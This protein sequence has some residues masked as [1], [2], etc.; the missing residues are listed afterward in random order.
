MKERGR[1]ILRNIAE[2]ALDRF[3]YELKIKGEPLRGYASFLANCKQRG[4]EVR[5]VFDGGVGFGTQ[6]LYNAFPDKKIVLIE[7][8]KE[9]VPVMEDLGRSYDAEYHITAL[10]ANSG[11]LEINVA[12]E[13][14]TSSSLKE[15]SADLAA[16]LKERGRQRSF[17]QRIIDVNRLDDINKYEPPFLLKLDVEGYEVEA[18]RGAEKTLKNTE[19]VIVEASLMD[20]YGDG[21]SFLD[22]YKFLDESGFALYEIVDMATRTSHA[23]VVYLDA[24]FVPKSSKLRTSWS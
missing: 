3:G 1:K 20:R 13:H 19:L 2:G 7:P 5:T 10:G 11:Q 14:L 23:P 22:I 16:D 6:W 24:A 8:L 18:L 15:Q 4:L 9:F 21:Q 12:Q 17:E